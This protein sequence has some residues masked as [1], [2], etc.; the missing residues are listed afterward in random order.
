MSFSDPL[1]SQ[2]TAGPWP[3][4]TPQRQWPTVS[5][6]HGGSV[7]R[8]RD[9][10][11]LHAVVSQSIPAHH[12]QK[13]T[14]HPLTNVPAGTSG[15]MRPL[16]SSTANISRLSRDWVAGA[17]ADAAACSLDCF[18]ARVAR[19]TEGALGGSSP[20]RC[21]EFCA[22]RADRSPHGPARGVT[23]LA[24]LHPGIISIY[25]QVSYKNW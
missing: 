9:V 23:S 16:L 12:S 20:F 5:F 19:G 10:H 11:A 17:D 6:E 22:A 8:G 18:C 24:N 7:L 21:M 14:M 1:K 4:H 25:F 15:L 2:C 3:H 13:C